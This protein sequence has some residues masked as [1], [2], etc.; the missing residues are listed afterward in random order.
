[1]E[2]RPTVEATVTRP[3]MHEVAL[4]KNLVDII[5]KTAADHGARQVVS[6][7][8]ELGALSCVEPA[9]LEFA[10]EIVSRGTAAE[11]SELRIRQ[12]PV[13]VQCPTC[14]TRGPGDLEALGCPACG[15]SPVRV[16]SGREMR[17]VSIDVE[18]N[19]AQD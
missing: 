16:L 12:M 8:L 5:D 2:V 13:I 15:A 6:A 9:A 11:G 7:T 14:N 3:A 19:H 4:A 17:L 18:E 10:Y 1:M